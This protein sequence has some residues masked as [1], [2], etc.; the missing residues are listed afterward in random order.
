MPFSLVCQILFIIL[1]VTQINI[2]FNNFQSVYTFESNK[3]NQ[4]SLITN[5]EQDA[6]ENRSAIFNQ[7]DGSRATAGDLD[8]NYNTLTPEFIAKDLTQKNSSQIAE[9]PLQEYSKNDISIV[10]NNLSDDALERVITS[11]N[12]D[13]I[14]II[15]EKFLPLER[16]PLYERLSQQIQDSI[17]SIL[18]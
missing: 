5:L 10:F 4:S 3:T 14:R 18:S 16:E 8:L 6:K 15:F 9:F 13:N 7:P 1:L 11:I 12:P 2:S 17:K